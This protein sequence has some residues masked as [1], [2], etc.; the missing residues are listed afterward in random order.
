MLKRIATVMLGL[1]LFVGVAHA[2]KF[3]TLE[4]NG[5]PVET[6]IDLDHMAD[7]LLAHNLAI[8]TA[9]VSNTNILTTCYMYQNEI[10]CVETLRV[11]EPRQSDTSFIFDHFADLTAAVVE[12]APD[13]C[14]PPTSITEY[15]KF[16]LYIRK[17]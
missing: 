12:C 5:G 16:I 13:P 10:I 4:T 6:A 3:K 9:G 7:T 2:N 17:E 1:C 11:M 8:T 15:N 14:P